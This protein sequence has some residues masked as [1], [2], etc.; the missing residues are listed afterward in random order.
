MKGWARNE[1]KQFFPTKEDLDAYVESSV[2]SLLLSE[3]AEAKVWKSSYMSKAS[4][5]K[6]RMRKSYRLSE[7]DG[8]LNKTRL[9]QEARCVAKC[10][11][12]GIPVPDIYMVDTVNYKLYMEHIEG[13]TLKTTLMEDAEQNNGSYEQ[14]YVLAQEI[15]QALS[16]MH[17]NDLVHGDLTSSNILVRKADDNN[18]NNNNNNNN[19]SSSSSS[20]SGTASSSCVLIDF[21]LGSVSC[22]AVEDKAVDLYVLEKALL[23]THPGSEGFTEALLAAYAKHGEEQ[24]GSNSNS[25][26]S[27]KDKDKAMAVL[28]RLEVVRQRGRKREMIG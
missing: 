8:K 4:V 18:N 12:L 24:Y 28:T 10:N 1:A 21:G 22:T 17:T 27:G 25:K 7:L 16:T 11:K 23:A 2:E 19:S 26:N 9:L 13:K 6:E 20:S 5:I 14:S 15:G 3:G